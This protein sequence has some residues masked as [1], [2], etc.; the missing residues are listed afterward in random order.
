[1]GSG[2]FQSLVSFFVGGWVLLMVIVF[3]VML[4]IYYLNILIITNERVIE[5]TQTGLF[6]RDIAVCPLEKIED[7]K[8]EVLGILPT[9]F[10]FGN[11]YIQTAAESREMLVHGIRYPEYAR[12]AIMK[13]YEE[14][15]LNRPK[16]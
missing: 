8:V 9:F 14:V 6:A 10:K 2:R 4:T 7:V 5:V 13:V 12:D 15:R 1:M 11:L 3:F 16:P